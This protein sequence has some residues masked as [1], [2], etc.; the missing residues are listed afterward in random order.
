MESDPLSPRPLL[1]G[2]FAACAGALAAREGAPFFAALAILA[3]LL[4]RLVARAPRAVLLAIPGALAAWPLPPPPPE[5]AL[6]AGPVRFSGTVA[7]KVVATHGAV[8]LLV[9]G[10]RGA[11]WCTVL[12]ATPAEPGD[13]I[14]GVGH[15]QVEADEDGRGPFVDAHPEGITVVASPPTPQR[16]LAGLRSHLARA[17]TTGLSPGDA[18]VL[19]QLVLGSGPPV[20]EPVRA[21]HRATG[22]SHL[23]AVSGA[24]VTLVATLLV[25]LQTRVLRIADGGRAFTRLR[26]GVV[27]AYALITGL[28]APVV[29]A[30][31]A[32]LVLGWVDA[33]GRRPTLASLLAGPA[34]LTALVWPEDLF[35]ISF[36]LSYAAVLGLGCAGGPRGKGRFER[37]VLAP[38]RASLWAVITTAPLTLWH[39][40]TLAPWTILATPLL[41][42]VVGVLLALGLGAAVLGALVPAS[43]GC[44]APLLG[45]GTEFYC[46]AVEAFVRLP[47]APVFAVAR[48]APEVL[49]AAVLL[50]LAALAHWRDRRGVLA[51]ALLTALPHALPA[52]RPNAAR[53]ALLAVGHGQACLV[54]QRD[55]TTLLVDCGCLGTPE[56]AAEIARTALLPRRR[57]DWLVVTHADA[58]HAGGVLRLAQGVGIAHAVLPDDLAHGPFGAALRAAGVLLHPLAPGEACAPR[59]H[60][61]VTRP[62]V[63]RRDR[64]ESSLWTTVVLDGAHVVVPGDATEFGT[65][66]WLAEATRPR[67]DALVLPHHGRKNA[68][69]PELLEALRPRV[70]LVSNRRG[71]GLPD[72]ARTARAAGVPVFTT[73]ELG[74]LT[75]TGGRVPNLV[76]ARPLR[77]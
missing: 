72:A 13:E 15:A 60:F 36:Q 68:A 14:R 63:E 26:T 56:R 65:R 19:S 42:P 16:L 27:V 66:A 38:G 31:A 64:N 59:E 61:V 71:E 41:A 33:R 4:A 37:W 11:F 45:A 48:P 5:A 39:F 3:A 9:R 54:A 44:L 47:G 67:V 8:R 57:L 46:A 7:R 76:S 69:T 2:A 77:W 43:A 50:G 21:A 1:L 18:A 58:D 62:K 20:P 30:A 52:P 17:L 55:G 25:L 29:R 74:T 73:G 53:L 75:L 51:L 12:G 32:F 35:S 23:L 40:G 24:H 34:L 10:E 22:L 28:E 70:A 49:G 6:V